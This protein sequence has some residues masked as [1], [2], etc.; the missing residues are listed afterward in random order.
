M[1]DAVLLRAWPIPTS[2]SLYIRQTPPTCRHFIHIFSIYATLLDLIGIFFPKSLECAKE[3]YIHSFMLMC[4]YMC[5]Y[6]Y[7]YI[8]QGEGKERK[9]M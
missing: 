7:I 3:V 2:L 6:I 4:I 1:V 9:N 8:Y 5:V